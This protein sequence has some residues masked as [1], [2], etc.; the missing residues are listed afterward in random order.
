MAVGLEVVGLE[1]PTASI[2]S[3]SAVDPTALVT[4]ALSA[5]PAESFASAAS[6]FSCRG[7]PVGDGGDPAQRE[8]W[9]RGDLT[10]DES[11]CYSGDDNRDT[12][13]YDE[14]DKLSLCSMD[15]LLPYPLHQVPKP[16][17]HGSVAHSRLLADPLL[18]P[19]P[20]RRTRPEWSGGCVART[21]SERPPPGGSPPVRI[22]TGRGA[23]GATPAG[24]GT[25]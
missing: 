19:S 4:T 13:G 24:S 20:P 8:W 3:A 11:S 6:W 2:G 9:E 12:A 14:D 17:L 1:L 16:L 25:Q 5:S 22:P 15:E 21:T 23:A 10:S 7:T 18:T